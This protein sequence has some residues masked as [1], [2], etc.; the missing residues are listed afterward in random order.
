MIN[1]AVVPLADFIQ[2]TIREVGSVI[3]SW[4]GVAL[5]GASEDDRAADGDGDIHRENSN[6][7]PKQDFC[8]QG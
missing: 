6:F 5:V 1:A 3:D 2:T 7:G 4:L 8:R